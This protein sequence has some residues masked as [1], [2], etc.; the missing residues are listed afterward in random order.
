M[1]L[2]LNAIFQ[3]QNVRKSMSQRS[4][5]IA[6]FRV[7]TGNHREKLWEEKGRRRKEKENDIEGRSGRGRKGRRKGRRKPP[8]PKML[9]TSLPIN[10]A[11][12]RRAIHHG[13]NTATKSEHGMAQYVSWLYN[14]TRPRDINLWPQNEEAVSKLGVWT[15]LTIEWEF[16][17]Y[18]IKNFF[19]NK[20]LQNLK[21][22]SI[23]KIKFAVMSYNMKLENFLD[24]K[25]THK[26][27]ARRQQ[28]YC[29][30]QTAVPLQMSTRNYNRQL[31][32]S[33]LSS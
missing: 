5:D 26:I 25:P 22:H 13:Y 6:R 19:K 10:S 29:I 33:Y 16:E 3:A 4:P 12:S 21:C 23:L 1:L 24:F 18:E 11:C 30:V 14:F 28:H 15:L 2:V 27:K 17:V 31:L 7:G 8:K 9:A 32:S 20:F